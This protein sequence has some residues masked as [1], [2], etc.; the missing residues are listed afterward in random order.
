MTHCY[1]HSQVKLHRLKG[2]LRDSLDHSTVSMLR[3]CSCCCL[4]VLFAVLLL[5]FV[6]WSCKGAA[7]AKG[8]HEG[9]WG[10]E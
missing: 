8:S 4:F 1:K 3:F 5:N 7:R 10:A 6:V 2:T 9:M